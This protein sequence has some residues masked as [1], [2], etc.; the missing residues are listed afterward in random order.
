MLK[1]YLKIAYRNLLKNKVFS[2]IN[3]LGLAIGMTACLLILQYVS[4][5]LSYDDFRK[6]NVYRVVQHRYHN[7]E[8]FYQ[9]AQT[10]PALTPALQQDMPEVVRAARVVGTPPLMSDPVMQIE[11]R[12]FHEDNIYFADSSFLN[13]FS[14]QLLEGNP[15]KALTQPNSVVIS[16]TM[17]RKYF[18]HQEALDQVLTFY[19]GDRGQQKLKVTGIFE[20][21]PE[22]SHLHTNF[23]I[24]FNSLPWNLDQVWDWG[25]FYNYVELIPD[26]DPTAVEAK[27]PALLDKY[28]G[29]VLE[30]DRKDGYTMEF[31]LQPL[32]GIHLDSHLVAEAEV[33]GSRSTVEFL[34]LIALFILVI[35]WIN[36][37][38]LTTAKATERAKEISIRKVAG[39]SRWQL[40][41]QFMTESL[42]INLLGAALAL[43]LSQLLLPA[44]RTFTG[45]HFSMEFNPSIGWITIV[46][47]VGG[48]LVSG[49]YPAFVLSSYQPIR[50]LK[51]NIKTSAG[52]LGLRKGLV[53]VQFA[54]SI[55]LIAGTFVVQKQLSFMRQQD[56][57]LNIDQTLIVKGPGIKDSTYQ[58][59]LA[60]FKQEVKKLPA[61]RQAGISSSI[62]GRELSWGRGFYLPEHPENRQDINI[63]AVDEDFFALYEATFLAGRNFSEEFSS[64]RETVI[65]NEEAIRLL[66]FEN[67]G[68][69]VGQSIIWDESDNDQH[70]K[71]IIGVVKDFNQESLHKKVGPMVF[72]LKR[73]LNAPWAGEY[74]SLKMAT[75][76]YPAALKEVQAVWKQAFNNSPFDYFFLD[77]FFNVQYQADQQFGKVFSL[78][79][80]LA[81]LIACLGL[82]GL[83]SYM[84]LQRTK[85]IGVRKVLGASV[86]NI[87]RL[88]SK[89]FARLILLASIII[90]PIIYFG[91]QQWLE[92]YAFR[93]EIQWWLLV[94]PIVL[95]W[96]L[97]FVTIIFQTVKAALANP[98]K[99]LRNE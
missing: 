91:M 6:P 26:T 48:A 85:E 33:N 76:D 43:T 35:A 8:K 97:A 84:T 71:R 42:L 95:V 11:D 73:Y 24:S 96:S 59:R 77:D 27:M 7:S 56:L 64:D 60:F 46:V 78:F 98:V 53:V 87:A 66:G 41:G 88:L 12:S 75:K 82:F 39:S 67:A 69:A 72:A 40:I 15:D 23:L 5:E 62:P 63:I 3:I 21:I 58:S 44:F 14:Y 89:D 92:N 68:Q 50:V 52:G 36:Y 4:F 20:D 55:A 18:P 65:F 54:A 80:G 93:I 81:I 30:E 25:N 99:S 38:N 19:M 2:L 79:A 94:L 83:S 9:R 16:A 32:Q 47:F 45:S 17:A 22:N 61:I 10:V 34:T 51:G 13:L 37:L 28:I 74:Y 31:A 86:Q 29:D 90:L 1:N 57:G 49:F 70:T